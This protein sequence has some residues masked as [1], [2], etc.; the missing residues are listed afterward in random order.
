MS[1]IGFWRGAVAASLL[2]F[3]SAMA[4]AQGI[5]V[6]RDGVRDSPFFVRS[7][8][9]SSMITDSLAETTVEQ[10]FGNGSS[11][12]QEGTYLFPLPDG[13]SVTSF[14]LRAGDKVIEGRLLGKDEARGIYES[15]VRRRRDPALLEYVGHSL[16]RASVFP[17]P[18]H[19]E[20]TL[21]LKYAEVLKPHGAVHRF[22][23]PLST[24]RFSIR[25]I[26][27]SSIMVRLKTST[28]LKTVYS[29]T[30]DVSI[31]RT[32]DM[33]ATAS[34]EG[35]GEFPDRDFQLFYAT[36]GDDVGLTLLTSPTGDDGG[37]FLLIASPRYAV[38]K[39][40][41][42]AK[43][44]VFVLDRT[45]SMQPNGKM[46]QAKSALKFCLDNLHPNDRFDVITFNESPDLLSGKMMPASKENVA[47][48]QKFV[49]DVEASGGTN[50]AEALKSAQSLL[51]S[52]EGGQK[53]IVFLTDGLPT[54]GETNVETILADVRRNNSSAAIASN[55]PD[56]SRSAGPNARIFCF[57]L[58]YDVN[59]PFLE[60]LAEQNRAE[61]DFVRPE[62]N[63]ESIVSTFYAKV[64]SP[65]LSNLKLAVDGVETVDVY[66]K[67]LPDL[68][69][70][71]QLIVT[72]KYRGSSPGGVKL[73]GY[74]GG[75][76]E[77]FKI[78]KAFGENA[79]R[80]SLVPRIWAVRKIG[81]L[82]DQVRLHSNQEVVDE[83]VRLSKQFGII[84]PY[85]S[86]LADERPEGV[87]PMFGGGG[88]IRYDF[89]ARLSDSEGA[90]K[91]LGSE[92]RGIVG[93]TET[94]RSLNSQG[95]KNAGQA[96]AAGQGGFYRSDRSDGKGY[97]D[98]DG[99]LFGGG[100]GGFG[101][102]Q[103]AAGRGGGGV[104]HSGGNIPMDRKAVSEKFADATKIVGQA[105]DKNAPGYKQISE[106]ASVQNVAGRTFFRKGN[107]W[108]DNN[109]P[110]GQKVVKVQALSDAHFQLLKARPELNKYASVGDEV[111]INLGK[112]SVQVGKDGKEKLTE[113]DLKEL[114]GK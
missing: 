24:G 14:S 92:S 65:V 107:I 86:Y 75:E 114:S 80:S 95:Y 2:L 63:I 74:V 50:I 35:R 88:G 96:P 8:R 48:A 77:T 47:K 73:V 53:M 54:V 28:P 12:E 91:R 82:L 106:V 9:I 43:N 30:H 79:A 13:A 100:G 99:L 52:A 59:V 62:E 110:S 33:N 32:D 94:L 10:I 78:E 111:V 37:Y 16:F 23:Y 20:R 46:E 67:N 81:Y 26:E 84:T 101:G 76:Q 93:E 60:H 3:A 87:Q 39:E 29:P 70:G 31:R 27:V 22:T 66:P 15:I 42:L 98:Y 1:K 89:H 68:F 112:V 6:P 56:E 85:T 83:I 102:G 64:S 18:P 7:V 61:A 4:Q 109:Y 25:P 55:G 72:G 21:T 38:P 17:I 34:W 105:K 19:G 41:I 71:G 104:A 97:V 45:G 108:F 103:G 51:K 90:L 57:G 69:K 36:S 113:A 40:K 58:G 49:R 11:F 5:M 44:I